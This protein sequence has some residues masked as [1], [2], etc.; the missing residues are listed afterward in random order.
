M[1]SSWITLTFNAARLGWEAQN[2]I[3][4]RLL[5]L[6]AGRIDSTDDHREGRGGPEA[7]AVATNPLL[8][9]RDFRPWACRARRGQGGVWGLEDLDANVD[10]DPYTSRDI[11]PLIDT[12]SPA[13]KTITKVR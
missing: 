6:A 2:V 4:L 12:S 5:R 3:A 8:H 13:F 9:H 11:S 7:Q 1:F 10:F